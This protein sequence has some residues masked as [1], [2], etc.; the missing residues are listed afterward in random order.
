MN[1]KEKE[2]LLKDEATMKLFQKRMATIKV[3]LSSHPNSKWL[4]PEIY[5]YGHEF[6][7]DLPMPT[8]CTDG[9]KIMI[10]VEF[11]NTKT[12]KELAA[13][14]LHE[15][16]HNIFRH[17]DYLRSK[18]YNPKVLNIATDCVVNSIIA[19]MGVGEPIKGSFWPDYHGTVKVKVA[20]KNGKEVEVVIPECAKKT[21]KYVYDEIMKVADTSKIGDNWDY[22]EPGQGDASEEESEV[23]ATN[24]IR[25]LLDQARM[26]GTKVPNALG[27]YFD[28]L[29]KPKVNLKR[30][31][32]NA[33][34]GGVHKY[35]SYSKFNK[36]SETLGV[37]LPG[38]MKEGYELITAIDTSGSISEVETKHALGMIYHTMTS[39]DRGAIN[40]R[41]LLHHTNVYCDEE[42]K[43]ENKI[44]GLKIQ[45]GGTSHID[46]FN[47]AEK[48]W[49][50]HKLLVC[51]TDGCTEYPES[52]KIKNV[53]WIIVNNEHTTPPFGKTIHVSLKDIQDL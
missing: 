41:V 49:K 8:M 5:K 10:D 1:K 7:A 37:T 18:N 34:V 19:S 25:R 53:I 24:N 21:W 52:T 2:K 4:T 9:K 43:D 39:L 46:V 26:Q 29:I 36:R 42:I 30:F 47:K 51:I 6:R 15:T 45:S 22:H 12:L 17:H 28:S 11:F 31:L 40:M 48:N 32:K 13:G 16:F 50:Q 44:K 14:E 35:N 33:I 3:Y 23:E 38:S 20:G 27:E